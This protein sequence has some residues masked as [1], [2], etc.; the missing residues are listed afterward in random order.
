MN[1]VPPPEPLTN[2]LIH[3]TDTAGEK[4]ASY[5]KVDGR[6]VGM[7]W[8]EIRVAIEEVAAGL[9]E[10]GVQR[11]DAV[12][13]VSQTRREWTQADFGI[14]MIGGI[15]VGI[16]PTLTGVQTRAL[17]EHAK[18]KVVFVEDR[19]QRV[20]VMEAMGDSG[21]SGRPVTVI[22]FEAQSD[23]PRVMTLDAL[24][25]NGAKRRLEAPDEIVR[26]A[27][28]NKSSDVVTYVYTSGTTG[29][30]KGAMLSHANF[31]YVIHATSLLIPY[32]GERTLAFLPLA[33]SL[34]RYVSYLGLVAD[35]N[36]YYAESLEKVPENLIEV[37]PTAFTLVPRV[38]EKI[39]AKVMASGREL[40][41]VKKSMF[42]GAL[43]SLTT[44]G[45]ARR[46]GIEPGVRARLKSN[47]GQRVVGG[48]VRAR[49]GGEVKFIGC[50]SAPLARDVHAFFEDIGVPILEGYGLTETSAPVTLNTLANRQI[51]T[52]GRPLP[53]TEVRLASDGE[54]LVKGPGV[55]SGY[56]ANP[57]ATAEAFDG[58]GWFKTGDIG[59]M[60]RTG[61]LTI[62]DRKKDLIITAG[63]KN[64]APQPIEGQLRRDPLIEQAV[65]IG[66]RRPYLVALFG[67]DPEVHRSLAAEHALGAD[68]DPARL[69]EVPEIKARIDR[70]VAAINA[71]RPS[72]EQ[73]KSWG[74]L[75][76]PLS[77]ET[78]ELTPTLK[79]KRREIQTRYARL[80]DRLY[81]S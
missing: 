35:A 19:P 64:I 8:R 30:S 37:K 39:H 21:I 48:R 40:T 6:W 45:E 11:G 54:V 50:G 53:G 9:L 29:E 62:T 80:I 47:I 31:H 61:F 68:M 51:G 1:V 76:A 5:A 72:F 38:L 56:F 73:V 71:E 32:E 27:R 67:L 25:R 74:V 15:T 4:I 52:V 65:L 43:R 63:G 36:G 59:T 55:F 49:L 20:K 69:A 79:V 44:A 16:Y 13:I 28:E 57:S 41:G 70:M 3:K 2:L 42:D 12:A 78:G 60:S 14:L 7:S 23:D 81:E 24:R 46:S 10:M 26:R 66:D 22:S 58:D 77:V 33:H 75:P 18:A 17:I 34:Q